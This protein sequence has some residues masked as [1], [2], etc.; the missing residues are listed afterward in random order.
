VDLFAE[1]ILSIFDSLTLYAKHNYL[2][3][4]LVLLLVQYRSIDEP[5]GFSLAVTTKQL[6]YL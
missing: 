4:I 6:K 5:K 2:A 1:N 3:E